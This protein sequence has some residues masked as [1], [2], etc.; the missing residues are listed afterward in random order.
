MSKRGTRW[1]AAAAKAMHQANSIP[2]GSYRD[3][4]ISTA[5]AYSRLADEEEQ[6]ARTAKVRKTKSA[7]AEGGP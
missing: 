4:V 7:Q 1:R 5:D 3:I 2:E 6:R